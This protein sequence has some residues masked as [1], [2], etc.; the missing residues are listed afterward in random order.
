MANALSVVVVSGPDDLDEF[1]A[2]WIQHNRHPESAPDFMSMLIQA[3]DE[4]LAPYILVACE[5]SKPVAMLIGR[6]EK[7]QFVSR[8]GYLNLARIPLVQ[9]VFVRDGCLGDLSPRVMD[10][11]LARLRADLRAGVADR[12]LLCNLHVGAE[13]HTALCRQ[14]G[15]LQRTGSSKIAEHWFAHLPTDFDSFL[16][17]RSAKHRSGFRR[18]TKRFESLNEG[19]VR[20]AVFDKEADVDAFCTAAESVARSTYQR[21]L[22]AGFFDNWENRQRLVLSARAGSLRAYVLFAGDTPLA[23]WAGERIGEVMYILW[24]A[25][26]PQHRKHEIGT[27]LFLKMLEDLLRHN[28]RTIDFGPGGAEYKERFGNLCLQEQDIFVYRPTPKGLMTRS[29]GGLNNVA[30]QVGRQLLDNLG[31]TQRLKKAWRSGLAA[32][33][34]GANPE[35]QG[36]RPAT[37]ILEED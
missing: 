20:Y 19:R 24:T 10:A 29:I 2:F 34:R 35:L 36:S 33:A 23:F 26:D 17:Q 3:R 11:M 1:R 22:G 7:A 30:N 16:A 37:P 31:I 15:T 5:D 27:I 9:L 6:R 18:M 21:G 14:F 4:V 32:R 28:V 13:L 25:F 12:A 8:I